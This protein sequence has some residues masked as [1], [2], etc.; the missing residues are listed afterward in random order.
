MRTP[1]RRGFTLIEL[2]VVIA[3]IAV[4]IALL[5]P[6]VQ[7]AREAARRAQCVNQL[8]Q[9]GLALHNYE[10]STSRFPPGT[11][12]AWAETIPG[13]SSWTGWSPH[14]MLLPYLEQ[15][16]LYNAAN[17]MLIT[18][19]EAP[20]GANANSTVV[21]TRIATF[22]CPSDGNAGQQYVNNYYASLGATPIQ[23]GGQGGNMSGL[24]TVYNTSQGN[25]A[26]CYGLSDITD[27]TSNTIAFGEGLVGDGQNQTTRSNGMTGANGGSNFPGLNSIF[28]AAENPTLVNQALQACNV[29]WKSTTILSNPSNP[30]KVGLK[31]Y[32]GRY[33]AM[34]ERGYTLFH[35]L[36]PPNSSD[37]IWRSCGFT[38]ANC[39]PESSAFVNANSNHP[40]GAN[41]TF[42]DGSVKFLKSSIAQKT[43]W[44]LGTKNAGETVSSDSY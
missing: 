25:R 39:A 23:G 8:R 22:L 3:I 24:F 14:A 1:P 27:G 40:G 31:S 26:N 18:A 20:L 29:Y 19:E 12:T 4:L 30:N 37:Y 17:F 16:P 35:T 13:L 36:V 15:T 43:Y 44:A 11:V 2:L 9:M 42:A 41:Y 32:V 7:S 21:R 34:G 38:C 5:L 10:S 33:W 28:N 6:A